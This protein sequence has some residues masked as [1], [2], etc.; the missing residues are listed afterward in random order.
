MATKPR[1]AT[2]W[3]TICGLYAQAAREG[4]SKASQVADRFHLKARMMPI[5]LT[6]IHTN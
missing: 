2:L 4:A 1:H 5:K 3:D 6:G